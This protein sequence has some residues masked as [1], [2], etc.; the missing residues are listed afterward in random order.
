MRVPLLNIERGPVVP[1]LNFGGIA[2]VPLLNFEGGLGSWVPESRGPSPTFTPCGNK[3]P[4]HKM[5]IYVNENN[6]CKV[7]LFNVL[8]VLTS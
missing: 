4:K 1:L 5:M 2:G 6:A 3:V 8:L 7:M